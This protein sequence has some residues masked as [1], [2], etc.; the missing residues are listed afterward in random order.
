MLWL[1]YVYC[2]C[3]KVHRLECPRALVS[4]AH[5]CGLDLSRDELTSH[6]NSKCQ[7]R[8][9]DCPHCKESFPWNTLEVSTAGDVI[10]LCA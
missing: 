10:T 1:L 7:R 6:L 9:V 4:C 8:P 5:K 3:I 2:L